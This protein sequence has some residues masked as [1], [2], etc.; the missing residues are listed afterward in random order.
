M[1]LMRKRGGPPEVWAVIA[2]GVR[3]EALNDYA[4]NSAVQPGGYIAGFDV[5]NNARL[6]V[7]QVY[8]VV[9]ESGRETDVQDVYITR[10]ILSKKGLKVV[11]EWDRRFLVDL[12]SLT[13]S[14]LS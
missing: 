2:N 11:D 4:Q 5:Q 9:Y 14:R 12:A 7:L 10:L 6:W 13:V 8:P 1:S 3:I